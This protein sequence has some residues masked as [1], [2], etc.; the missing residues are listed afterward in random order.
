MDKYKKSFLVG[1]LLG[2]A[3]CAVFTFIV[4]GTANTANVG[5]TSTHS[6]VDKKSDGSDNGSKCFE[7]P[8]SYEGKKR[9]SVQ[10]IQV[11]EDSALAIEGTLGYSGGIYY[12]GKI[13]MITGSNHYTDEIVNINNP[14]QIGLYTYLN[15]YGRQMTVPVIQAESD[16]IN[17]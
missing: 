16:I 3:I 9:V 13:V 2:L 17:K 15:G 11:F 12:D 4:L 7:H 5:D 10:V 14:Q 1:V 8:I 6:S